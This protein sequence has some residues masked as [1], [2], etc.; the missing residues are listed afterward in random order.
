V[1]EYINTSFPEKSKT[2]D[3]GQEE[4]R[5]SYYENLSN[6]SSSN[7]NE[8]KNKEHTYAN[9]VQENGDDGLEKKFYENLPDKDNEQKYENCPNSNGYLELSGNQSNCE[10]GIEEYATVEFNFYVNASAE[11]TE[12][13]DNYANIETNLLPPKPI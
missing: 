4:K 11:P 10:N 8:E 2:S 7:L 6:S 12:A 13:E 9:L 3:N 5:E 1:H